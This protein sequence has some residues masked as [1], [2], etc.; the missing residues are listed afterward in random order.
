MS[1]ENCDTDIFVT[2]ILFLRFSLVTGGVNPNCYADSLEKLRQHIADRVQKRPH[3]QVYLRVLESMMD[4]AA[5][6]R[7]A[8]R[9]QSS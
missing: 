1:A 4:L 9:D 5:N 6:L 2:Y 3:L 7:I 8:S